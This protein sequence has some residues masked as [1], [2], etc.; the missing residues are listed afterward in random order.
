MDLHLST[1]I[2]NANLISTLLPSFSPKVQS[3]L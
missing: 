1:R 2:P 3:I